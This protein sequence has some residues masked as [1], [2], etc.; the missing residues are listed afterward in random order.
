MQKFKS[1]IAE[2]PR[3]FKVG[4]K[5]VFVDK[6]KKNDPRNYQEFV[7]KRENSDNTYTIV[8]DTETLK[9]VSVNN[10]SFAD[11]NRFMESSKTTPNDF[12]RL[13][14]KN[15]G[16]EAYV[17]KGMATDFYDSLNKGND[18]KM[19]YLDEMEKLIKVMRKAAVKNPEKDV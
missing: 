15:I 13:P 16:N 2:A 9:N 3:G 6:N 19:Y 14:K 1:F 17:L 10:L 11:K 5:V 4:T 8:N 12:Y 7:I 18:L